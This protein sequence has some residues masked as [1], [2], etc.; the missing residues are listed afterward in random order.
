MLNSSTRHA[1][2]FC[3]F[4]FIY[5]VAACKKDDG[6]IV[7][8]PPPNPTGPQ[9]YETPFA[10]VANNTSDLV[11]YEIN[12]RAFSASGTLAGILPRL[13]SI[14]ALGVN[15]IW[16]M[17]IHPIGVTKTVNSPYCI[18]NYKE[19]NTEFG[20][21]EDLRTLV[22]EAH[23]RKIAVILDWVA[24]HTSWDNPWVQQHRDW[25]TQDANGNIIQPAG[26]NWADVADLNFGNAAMRLEMIA[27]M[28]YWLLEA[29]MDGF[30]CDAADLVPFS[31][32]K[33]AIDSLRLIPNR[34]LILLAEGARADHFAAGFQLN[35]GWGY[36][37]KM[38]AVFGSGQPVAGLLTTHTAEYASLPLGV[39][40]LRFT[41][42][43]D[44]CA[45]D[46]TPIALFGGKDASIAAF[47]LT[48]Y[49]GGVPLIYNGQEVACPIKLPFFSRLPIDWT[50][51]PAVMQQY[52]SIMAARTAHVALRSG[53][54]TYLSGID[55]GLA[56][57]KR[58][59]G[60]DEVLVLVNVRS[61][62]NLYSLPAGIANTNWKDA[63]TGAAVSLQTNLTFNAYEYRVLVAE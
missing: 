51:N 24:N 46:N 55:T 58:K 50:I 54:L 8:P 19:V 5:S 11:L 23:K 62:T 39:H 52:K 21:L 28:K 22:R 31:F 7:V 3:M 61:N 4:A 43:H 36:F 34:K 45:W 16:L 17:P 1:L 33:Q 53:D 32:W 26:T 27:S 48:A 49:Q 15:T 10:D 40:K 29:N 47:V 44:E 63:Y 37:N 14:K 56:A 9:Q 25:Y 57:F 59:S 60:N 2:I 41:S 30:R 13:D 42:N 12:E 20:N 6:N 35:F 18:A 38:K